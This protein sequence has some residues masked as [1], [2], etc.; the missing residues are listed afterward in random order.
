MDTCGRDAPINACYAPTRRFTATAV[1]VAITLLFSIF[2]LAF[3]ASFSAFSSALDLNKASL[4][5]IPRKALFV[6]AIAGLPALTK[7]PGNVR[8]LL[9]KERVSTHEKVS[10]GCLLVAYGHY[11]HTFLVGVTGV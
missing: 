3:A 7:L 2:F 11:C 9:Q 5:S 1:E 8:R 10:P 6:F 4:P